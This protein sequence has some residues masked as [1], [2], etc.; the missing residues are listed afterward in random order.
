MYRE[1][2]DEIDPF[3][4]F[5][6]PLES[7]NGLVHE[8]DAAKPTNEYVLN[9]AFYSFLGFLLIEAVFALIARSESML[10][11]SE[12]MS[13][14]AL[15]YLFNLGAERYKHRPLNATELAMP[16]AQRQHQR[17]LRRL[18][19]EL[20]PPT[21]SVVT[22]I[23]VTIA[24]LREALTTLSNEQRDVDHVDDDVSVPIM[25]LF[26]AA[27]LLLD[28]V[29]VTCFARAGSTFGLDVVRRESASIQEG[30]AMRV[31][32][33]SNNNSSVRADKCCSSSGSAGVVV[34]V[35]ETSR[36]IPATGGLELL[37]N[38]PHK[39]NLP[40]G[41]TDLVNLNMCSAWTVRRFPLFVAWPFIALARIL[42]VS[43][44]LSL[45]LSLENSTTFV[46]VAVVVS[47]FCSVP[48]LLYINL[49]VLL[50]L[51][52]ASC[53]SIAARVRGHDAQ[54][55]RSRGGGHCHCRSCRGATGTGRL[56]GGRGRVHYHFRQ[57]PAAAPGPRHYGHAN[58]PAAPEREK[59]PPL[60]RERRFGCSIVQ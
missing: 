5:E 8:V 6:D 45:S 33:G 20:V 19:L 31:S 13:V 53:I 40:H 51:S 59:F 28:V 25:L 35:D 3:E 47:H 17:E 52:R 48:C 60:L 7:D 32:S 43:R 14:D 23:L 36:L 2:E 10:A 50:L 39:A 42:L 24:T 41:H 22:L 57:P 37:T 18:Y 54:Y 38:Q 27:N 1:D 29:N 58:L 55:R 34:V 12:A 30:I 4:A 21:I 44:S 26:S 11:D 16:L 49:H 46:C 56:G 15:T 9:V